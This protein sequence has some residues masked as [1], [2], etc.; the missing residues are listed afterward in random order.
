M[1]TRSL[2]LAFVVL[3]ACS[4]C[5]DD[6]MPT[7]DAPPD[8]CMPEMQV[9]GEY[10]DW[11]STP[12]TFRGILGASFTLRSDPTKTASTAPNGRFIL[13]VPAAD[14][15]IDITPMS[16]SD[17]I[18][19][20]LVVNKAVIQSGAMLS[21]RSFTTTRAAD[22]GFSMTQAHVFVHVDGGAQTASTAANASVKKHF[23]NGTWADGATGTDIY[24]GNVDPQ[25]MTALTVT[26]SEKGAGSIPLTAGSFT[27]VTVTT[28]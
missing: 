15:I 24:L 19:G 25:G 23:E 13:C 4:A 28:K 8:P 18:G 26:N 3:A 7:I 22:F 6:G 20:S 1:A 27:Y 14:G 16:G 9:T 17:Y 12:A 5:G 10:V 11:D 21:L 2:C